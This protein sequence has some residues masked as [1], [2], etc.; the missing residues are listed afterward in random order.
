MDFIVSFKQY[1]E[2]LRQTNSR[3][4]FDD[5]ELQRRYGHYREKMLARQLASFFNN[6]KEKQW[7]LEKYHPVISRDRVNDTKQRRRERL[8]LFLEALKE[9]KYDDVKYDATSKTDQDEQEKPAKEN[10]EAENDAMEVDTSKESSGSEYEN[11]LV[12]KTVPPTIAR[13]KIIEVKPGFGNVI[14]GFHF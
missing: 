6:N 10:E 11:H 2:Y 7:F 5:E 14:R 8:K 13:Q 1:C 3:R 4:H 9:G 12:I